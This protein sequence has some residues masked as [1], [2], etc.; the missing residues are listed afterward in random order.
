MNFNF[1]TVLIIF[2]LA[3]I[4]SCAVR[5]YPPGG[6]EDIFPPKLIK[7][8]PDINSQNISNKIEIDIWFDEMLNP[9]TVQ[10]SNYYR[11][12]YRV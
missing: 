5:S 4:S 12:G 7:V 6:E 10:S 9:N 1:K 8:S 11:T 3:L 2:Y